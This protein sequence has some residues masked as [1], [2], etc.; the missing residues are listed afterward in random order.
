MEQVTQYVISLADVPYKA[1]NQQ[2]QE[3]VQGFF[4]QLAK[5]NTAG[6]LRYYHPAVQYKNPWFELQGNEVMEM[7]Q[8]WWR[9]LPDLKVVVQES[10]IRTTFVDWQ[11]HYTFPPTARYI[12]HQLSS[13]LTVAENKII[14]HVDRFNTHQWAGDAYGYLGKVAGGWKLFETQIKM[15]IQKQLNSYLES[16]KAKSQPY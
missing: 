6:L 8:M 4:E 10:G 15:R 7:W 11:A 5:R 3:V 9:Y 16:A 12:K 13:T 1:L 2:H 14:Q